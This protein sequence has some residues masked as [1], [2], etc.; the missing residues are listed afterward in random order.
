MWKILSLVLTPVW[1]SFVILIY[2]SL[3]VRC[4]VI[5]PINKS[6]L[7]SNLITCPEPAKYKCR[8][9]AI[10]WWQL[11][12]IPIHHWKKT[13]LEKHK[14]HLFICK[15]GYWDEVTFAAVRFLLWGP[16]DII[17]TVTSMQ[18]VMV[19]VCLFLFHL[20]RK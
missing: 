16:A 15:Q 14:Q 20:D 3:F 8:I 2:V 12:M 19:Q 5:K 9:S 10:I 6:N 11:K 17:S 4:C 13:L 18:W 7:L 1:E